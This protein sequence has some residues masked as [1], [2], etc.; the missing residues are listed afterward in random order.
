M[1]V[2][3]LGGLFS[4]TALT[5]VV[6]PVAYSVVEEARERLL[7]VRGGPAEAVP[8]PAGD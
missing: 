2:A 6:I 3:V 1:A 4:A 7:A 5:L 8:E